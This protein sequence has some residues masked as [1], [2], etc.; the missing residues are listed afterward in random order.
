MNKKEIIEQLKS[1]NVEFD[2]K[3]KVTELKLLLESNKPVE[4]PIEE[5]I[6]DKGILCPYCKREHIATFDGKGINHE[7]FEKKGKAAEMFDHL[8]GQP[9]KSAMY[10]LGM[11]EK[12]GAVA[13][14]IRN[15]LKINILKG[16]IIEVPE[17]IANS[18]AESQKQNVEATETVKIF[19]TSLGKFTN[20]K[21]DLQSQIAREKLNA[22]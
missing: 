20:P 18:I 12:L 1:L 5:S 10:P 7:P 3:A 21:L 9:K 8:A 4:K 19:N 22:E 15:G 16:V 14:L 17:D 13:T 11:G 6:E 2:D